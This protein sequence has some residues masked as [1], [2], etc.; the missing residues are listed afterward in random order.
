MTEEQA[1]NIAA[2]FDRNVGAVLTP[3]L[4][5]GMYAA[6]LRELNNEEEGAPNGDAT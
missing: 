1:K 2:I 4:A 5:N 6:I 3:E